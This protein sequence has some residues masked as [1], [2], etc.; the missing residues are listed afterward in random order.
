L[1]RV[2]ISAVGCYVPPRVLTNLDLEAMVETSDEWIVERTGIHERH[3]AGPGQATS[4]L[5]VEAARC[6]LAQRGIPASDVSAIIVCTVTP[7]MLFPSTA[8]LVQDRLEA[9]GAWGFD[10]VAACSGFLYGLTTGAHLVAGGAHP[11]V[12]V[13][14]ADTMSRIIDYTDRATCV[15]FGDGAGAMLLEAAEDGDRDLG[16]IDFLGEVDGSGGDFLK[17]PAGGSRVPAS[18]ESVENRLHYVHQD[19]QQVFKYA[20]RKM[21][22][23][24]RDLLERNHITGDDVSIMIPHQANRRIILAAAE[25]LCIPVERI[26]I[27]IDRYGN[28]TAGTI[29]LATRDAVLQGRLKKGDLVLFAAVGA[30]YTVGASLW[31]WAY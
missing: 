7:D 23:V 11:K 26:L 3:I 28:T 21:Y 27:N 6:A 19:G 20:V 30:G 17:M 24:C 31:R 15:L 14:G 16:F 10:L 8:C 22:E 4:D 29:P 1:T 18:T 12:L 2:K 25:R 5:A 13:I 9:R